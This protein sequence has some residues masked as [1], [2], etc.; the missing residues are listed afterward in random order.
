MPCSGFTGSFLL[1]VP[2]ADVCPWFRSVCQHV[3]VVI[4][5]T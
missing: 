3:L 5:M 2:P 1:E 4:S